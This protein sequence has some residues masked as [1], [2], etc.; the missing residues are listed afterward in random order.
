MRSFWILS[1]MA[2]G[3]S[4]GVGGLPVQVVPMLTDLGAEKVR[5]AETASPMGL[6]TV[7]GWIGVG[8]L[9]TVS[10]PPSS[11]WAPWF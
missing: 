11:W 2:V 1:L 3:M 9:L 5:A 4:L 8:L 7:S 10:R 6:A